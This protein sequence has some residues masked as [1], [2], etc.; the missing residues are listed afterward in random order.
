MVLLE[1]SLLVYWVAILPLL[2]MPR[3]LHSL[4]H[5]TDNMDS[6]TE[7]PFLSMDSWKVLFWDS[8]LKQSV[9]NPSR[10]AI[11]QD[12]EFVNLITKLSKVESC[13]TEIKT[14]IKYSIQRKRNNYLYICDAISNGIYG[15]YIRHFKTRF[16]SSRFIHISYTK[17][18]RFFFCPK[19]VSV[20]KYSTL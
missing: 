5:V 17:F 3:W 11:A 14:F 1:S 6:T 10:D 13:I 19:Y 7:T 15:S 18:F 12:V 8:S 9:F 20:F 16:I 4:G 2:H